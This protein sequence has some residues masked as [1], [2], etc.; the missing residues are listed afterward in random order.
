VCVGRCFVDVFR[1]KEK[2]I[3]ITIIIIVVIA[4]IALTLV[5]CLVSCISI[6]VGSYCLFRICI[7]FVFEYIV[8]S[9]DQ[10]FSLH[11]VAFL[12]SHLILCYCFFI[13]LFFSFIVPFSTMFIFILF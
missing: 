6:M 1:E 10:S 13:F 5:Y 3:V 4:H 9:L 2:G 11:I 12:I 7:H 8:S